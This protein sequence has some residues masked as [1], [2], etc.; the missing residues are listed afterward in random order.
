MRSWLTW[1]TAGGLGALVIVGT[2][3][4]LRDS[5]SRSKPALRNPYLA[6]ST[7]PAAQTNER[8]PRCRRG[9]LALR[10]EN[11]NGTPTLELAHV[12]GEPCRTP[13]LRI[14]VGLL[15]RAGRALESQE[16]GLTVQQTIGIQR[17][18]APTTL[19]PQVAVSAVFSQYVYLCGTPK[20]VWAV[21][22]AGPY[23][24]RGRLPRGY[25]ACLDDLGP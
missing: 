22:E 2:I 12:S 8:P 25:G 1:L 13:R 4:A 9:Q 7:A 15:D 19:A 21:A 23:S 6:P 14:Q 10:V 20:P 11:L 24:A 17:A 18:F 5:S 16:D 3:D